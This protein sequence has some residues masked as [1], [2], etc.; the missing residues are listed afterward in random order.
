M[1]YQREWKLN[2][3]VFL[4][5]PVEIMK[6][7]QHQKWKIPHDSWQN[8]NNTQF[9][10][11]GQKFNSQWWMNNFTTNKCYANC[12]SQIHGLA[13]WYFFHFLSEFEWNFW[14]NVMKL[15]RQILHIEENWE[16]ETIFT[17]SHLHLC[18]FPLKN[19]FSLF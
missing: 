7:L 4:D 11:L 5:I 17:L 16:I 10:T 14:K 6:K 2:K 3:I 18:C 15:M 19:N 1:V 9:I 12:I 13:I 8:Y